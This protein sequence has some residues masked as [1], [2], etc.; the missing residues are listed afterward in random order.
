M[1]RVKQHLKSIVI[2]VAILLAGTSS[3]YAQ[4]VVKGVVTD[5]TG[6]PMVGVTVR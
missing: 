5:A 1:E 3:V 6:E 2:L 4:D